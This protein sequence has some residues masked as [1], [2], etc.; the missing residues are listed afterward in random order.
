MR[1][2]RVLMTADCVGGVWSYSLGLATA[3]APLGVTVDLA[4][5]GEPSPA[6]VAAAAAVPGLRLH[7]RPLAL[8][9][10]PSPWRDVD[11]ASAWLR[12]LAI[13]IG[14]DVVHVNGYAA[15]AA[16]FAA[17]VV[18]VAHSCVCSWWRAVRGEDAPAEWDEYRRR[19][20]AGIAAARALVAPTRAIARAI[21]DAHGLT[22]PMEVIGNGCDPDRHA[23]AARKEP[24]VLAAGRLWDDAKNLVALE[25]CAA[26][27]RWPILVAGAVALAGAPR[28]GTCGVEPLGVLAPA[29]LAAWMGRAAI[30]AAPA[31]Y[32]PFGL[33]I[34]EAAQAGCALVLGDIPT[35]RELWSGAAAFVAP[36]DHAGLARTID[37][38]AADPDRRAELAA[39]ARARAIEMT[40]GRMAAHYAALYDSLVASSAALASSAAAG[41]GRRA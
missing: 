34:L 41:S 40:A 2:R 29:E 10:M 37:R 1:A 19:V 17:P 26:P 8:E 15:A 5:M 25:A 3:L 7:A 14:A 31:R 12:G 18:V 16:G 24:F 11:A 39:A 20:V 35:L 23:P 28:R 38:L 32:E 13:E 22:V 27:G 4:V 9:W 33:A 36:D 21:G 30:F 6:Q